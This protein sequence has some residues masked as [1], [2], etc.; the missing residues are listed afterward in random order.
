MLLLEINTIL[1]IIGAIF[2]LGIVI[3]LIVSITIFTSNIRQGNHIR[4]RAVRMIFIA[5]LIFRSG[6]FST[7]L[8][9]IFGITE[10]GYGL[11][12]VLLYRDISHLIMIYAITRFMWLMYGRDLIKKWM[13]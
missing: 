2:S 10:Q 1:R 12:A 7:S 3:W 8:L 4:I 5:L 11:T 6:D 13:D 9:R